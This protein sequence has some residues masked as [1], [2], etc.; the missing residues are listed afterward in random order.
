MLEPIVLI[1]LLTVAR[2]REVLDAKWQ[3]IDWLRYIW[4][5]PKTKS[6]KV[7][8][9]PLTEA[10]KVL[11]R[12]RLEITGGNSSYIF[13]NPKTDKPFQTVFY[14]WDTP[15]KQAGLDNLRMHDLRHSLAIAR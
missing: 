4:K 15:R 6:G 11:L 13:A 7:Q 9:V 12:S 5:I 14:S 8:Y 3:N 2:K 1:L 10:I